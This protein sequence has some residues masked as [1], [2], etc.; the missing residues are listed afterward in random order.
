MRVLL[1]IAT[2]IGVLI[3]QSGQAATFCA[4]SSNELQF[5]LDAAIAN[6][7][8]DEVRIRQ[9][10]YVTPSGGF[11]YDSDENFDLTISGGWTGIGDSCQ[12]QSQSASPFLTTLD[13]SSANRVL[14]IRAGADSVIEVDRL[15]FINGSS[16]IGAGLAV[17]PP[18]VGDLYLT[19]SAFLG[20][21][22]T[23]SGS[24]LLAHGGDFMVI[25]NNVF[26]A[27]TGPAV[28][29]I[30]QSDAYGV[31]LVNNTVVGNTSATHGG[32]RLFV[33]GTSKQLVANNVLWNNDG[34]DLWITSN[35]EFFS[36]NNNIEDCSCPHAGTDNISTDPMFV[37]GLLSFTPDEG[38]PLVDAGRSPPTFVPI[39]PP[40]QSAWEL[41]DFDMDGADRLLGAGV[42]MGAIESFPE[43]LFSNG[44]E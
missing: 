12:V 18:W 17:F 40:F 38:S 39:P 5:I 24:A 20:N 19:R 6:G 27:N 7:Q 2:A 34:N 42:D 32:V 41:G 8:H 26:A 23:S 43:L 30:S 14:T 4:N 9:G 44:F 31:H 13:G 3:G 33:F 21:T 22:A 11:E 1:G 16:A 28:M 25:R 37:S 36:F 35:G 10:V 29:D 15:L